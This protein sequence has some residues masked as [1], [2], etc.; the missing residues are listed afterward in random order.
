MFSSAAPTALAPAVAFLLAPIP[1]SA[2]CAQVFEIAFEFQKHSE[3]AQAAQSI[4]DF[5]EARSECSLI[6]ENQFN[7][8]LRHSDGS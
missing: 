2:A 1:S 4:C 5:S 7:F 6:V 3:S 8:G